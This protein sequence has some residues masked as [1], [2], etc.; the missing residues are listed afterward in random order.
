MQNTILT[1]TGMLLTPLLSALLLVL[2]WQDVR[3][4][5]VSLL[6][7]LL[8][9]GLCMGRFLLSSGPFEYPL[10]NSLFLLIQGGAVFVY[11]LLRYR[12]LQ[13]SRY[14]GAGDLLFWL[15]CLWCFSPLNFLLFFILSLL[16]ALVLHGGSRLLMK[17][18]EQ[19]LVPLAGF[20]GL[21]LIFAFLLESL[22]PDWSTYNDVPLL[23]TLG[24]Y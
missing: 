12:N 7:L 21:F 10:I 20:Q 8:L 5:K 11:L 23:N 16:G 1:T 4:R 19:G 15:A 14:L 18:Y 6:L 2:C 3:E 9:I 22:I 24:L 17:A 13:L